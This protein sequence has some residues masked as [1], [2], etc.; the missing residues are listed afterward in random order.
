MIDIALIA[1][2]LV[3]GLLV[4][5]TSIGGV[6]VLPALVILLGMSPHAAIPATMVG[7]IPPAAMS[8][9]VVWRSGQ[10]DP[11]A[12]MAIW[13]GA[14]PGAFIGAAIL[15][16]VSVA[17]LLWAIAAMLAISAARVFSR[18]VT[19]SGDG[20][21]PP[22]AELGGL[23]FVAGAVSALTGT[24]GP[25]TLMPMLGWRGVEPRRAVVLCQ[26][27][28]FPVV[29]FASF[30]YAYG[31]DL[32]W[33]LV[34]FLGLSASVGVALGTRMASR[35]RLPVLARLIGAMMAV[36]AV[37]IVARQLLG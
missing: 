27:I 19:G 23:G 25:V 14:V 28:T 34:F 26:A 24:G 15:P 2:G 11:R 33:R 20:R 17:A 5:L 16:W 30:G 6:L 37:V 9:V 7:F 8:L 31:G 22:A 10:L 36:T 35:V 3:A 29:V 4:G 18:P 32:D 12:A 13:M 21:T 1:I